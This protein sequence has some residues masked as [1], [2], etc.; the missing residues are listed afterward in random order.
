VALPRLDIRCK[1]DPE[2]HEV[3]TRVA[4]RDGKDIGEYVEK[5]LVKALSKRLHEHTLDKQYFADLPAAGQKRDAT[6]KGH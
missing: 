5:I 4:A 2:W 3:L 6:G 1:L